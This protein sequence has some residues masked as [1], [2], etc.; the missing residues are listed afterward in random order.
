MKNRKRLLLGF[1]A[2]IFILSV[3][4]ASF[5]LW[6]SQI[7]KKVEYDYASGKLS[8][9]QLFGEHNQYVIFKGEGG[10][11][12]NYLVSMKTKAQVRDKTDH[13]QLKGDYWY[14]VTRDLRTPD[15]KE[16]KI[17]LYAALKNYDSSVVPWSWTPVYYEG[18]DYLSVTIGKN[19]ERTRRAFLDLETG[20]FQDPPTGFD[21]KAYMAEINGS[22]IYS[23]TSLWEVLEKNLFISL[24]WSMFFAEN[25]VENPKLDPNINFVKD[26]PDVAKRF[27]QGDY[28]Y[29]R[30]GLVTRDSLYQ[31]LRHWFA[32]VGQDKLEVT[33]TDKKTGEVTVVNTYQDYR[34]WEE[35]HKGQ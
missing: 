32:P 13:T 27:V 15:L 31:D 3:G 10:V 23:T 16:K 18:R 33:A 26:H 34:A 12:Q 19:L 8:H 22:N 20:K 14:V 35:A 5:Y 2:L 9:I 25:R 29:P 21:F 17:D 1:L 4:L 11:T 28:I 24:D 7:F 6:K 30:K